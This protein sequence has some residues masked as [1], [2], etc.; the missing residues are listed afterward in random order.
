MNISA[1]NL[2]AVANALILPAWL[3]LM[4]APRWRWTHRL[5]VS[6]LYSSLYALG[7]TL[8]IVLNLDLANFD[9]SSLDK[10]YQLFSNPYFLLAGWTHYLAFDLLIGAWIVE[11]SHENNMH[12]WLVLPILALTFYFGPIGYLAY[13]LY[14]FAKTKQRKLQWNTVD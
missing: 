11:K 13:M 12:Y 10:I 3:M 2:F 8:L 6:G 9:F 1:E 5:V 14:E 4:L 7:Y